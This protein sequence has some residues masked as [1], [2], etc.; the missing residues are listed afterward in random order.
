MNT[1]LNDPTGLA[2]DAAGD[3]Y[4]AD[5]GNGCVREVT[6]AQVQ[7]TPIGQCASD[8][9]GS[10][11][12]PAPNFSPV[13]LA[14]GSQGYLYI[15]NLAQGTVLQYQGP[16]ATTAPVLIAGIPNS[17][18]PYT[19]RRMARRPSLY[20]SIS[21]PVCPSIL[22]AI[23]M[24]RTVATVL[25]A[26]WLTTISFH[27]RISTHPA[28]GRICSLRSMP[29]STWPRRSPRNTACPSA[30]IPAPAR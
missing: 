2:I 13:G 30:T 10:S 9:S 6:P 14:A 23:F 4:V 28:A 11:N 17:T 3:Y 20:R 1:V 21:R 24:S 22:P 26:S 15:T 12:P 7:S 29:T 19:A 25:S 27:P 16:D 18:T 8:G 5:T